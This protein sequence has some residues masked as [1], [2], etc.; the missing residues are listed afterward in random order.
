LALPTPRA[1]SGTSFV[2]TDPA[3]TY[4]FDPIVTGATKEELVPMKL[5][6]PI[7]VACLSLPS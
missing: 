2:I 7:L 1:S 6:S 3:A 5:L 4:A